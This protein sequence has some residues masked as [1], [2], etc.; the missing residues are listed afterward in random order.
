MSRTAATA[1]GFQNRVVV[2]GLK[3]AARSLLWRSLLLASLMPVCATMAWAADP[4]VQQPRLRVAAAEFSV[5]P[6]LDASTGSMTG[7][8]A[9]EVAG[10]LKAT[11]LLL[12]GPNGRLCMVTSHIDEAT[13]SINVSTRLRETVAG[14][15]GLPV[16]RV[17]L[18]S[19]HNHSSV[20]LASNPISVYEEPAKGN[21][22]AQLLPVGEKFVAELVKCVR[23]L[24]GMLQPVSVWWAEGCESRITYNRKGRRAD[25]STYF[26]REEDR[27]LV[28]KDFNGDIDT[29]APVVVFKNEAG[30]AVAALCQFTGHPVTS[31]KPEKPVVF[32]DWPQ[33]AA[34]MVAERLGS[35]GGVP[36]GF[37]QGCA[38][39]VNSKEMFTGGVERA[40][41][42]GRMLGDSYCQALG[43]LQPSK[44]D[45]F[46]LTVETV[47]V[48]LAPL[49]SREVLIAELEEMDDFVRRADAG[50]ENTRACVGLNFPRALSPRYR[51]RLI[52]PPR[53]WDRW[54]L[55][56]HEK[57]KADSVA[58]FLEM[59]ITL[60]RVGDVGIVGL[61]CEPFQGIGRQIR[62]D[63]P[64]ALTIPC[65]YAN[66]TH[67]Y[68]TD[69]A[70]TGGREYMSAF[71]RYTKYRPPLAKPAGDVLAQRAVEILRTFAKE[72]SHR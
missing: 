30:Q 34:E 6:E 32:G 26:M 33:V 13:S 48:P 62:R 64:L 54:A 39:D 52:D 72:S 10:P 67:G 8:R 35:A 53:A 46:D 3:G 27:A 1:S 11:V 59:E 65:G 71:Y 18:F 31:Y 47:R 25:G 68:I 28:G 20:D 37:M 61:P 36:V 24:P 14:E 38:G 19:S 51:A 70:N 56:L 21:P 57:G 22:P 60:L 42:F 2:E 44:H 41:Q 66:V 45:G 63:S 9:T 15:L 7:A 16:S 69:G 58:K 23:A 43:K 5:L 12:D 50:D 40:T 4:A 29:Q 55:D 17:W 49:P